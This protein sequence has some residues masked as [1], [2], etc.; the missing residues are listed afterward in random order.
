MMTKLAKWTLVL[1]IVVGFILQMSVIWP[2]GSH[3]CFNSQC[4]IFFWG[5]NEHDAVWHL[6]LENTA[7][8]TNPAQMPN[9][10]GTPLSGYNALMDQVLYVISYVTGISVA[11]LYFKIIP[12][13]WFVALTLLIIKLA[14]KIS[15]NPWYPPA[16]LFFVYLG[17]SFSYFLTLWHN[18]TW[19]GGSG[20]LS[21]QAPQTL[22]NI[23]FGL[24]LPILM[25]ILI[26]MHDE[27]HRLAKRLILAGLVAVMW[28]L[29]F[30]GGA[31][32]AAMVGVYYLANREQ[33]GWKQTLSGLFILG[34]MTVGAIGLFYGVN[35]LASGGST[36]SWSPLTTVHPIIEEDNL[37]YLPRLANARYSLIAQG[38][39]PKL[40]LIEA[41][42][43]IIFMVLNFGTRILGLWAIGAQ[44]ARH[45]LK[46]F[47]LV[48]GSGI[49]LSFLFS[50]LLVQKGVWWNTVQFLYYSLFLA[51]IYAAQTIAQLLGKKR[52]WAVASAIG[53]IALT[54]PNA[55]DTWKTFTSF[56]P[57]SYIS[58]QEMELLTILKKQPAGVVLALPLAATEIETTAP[59]APLYTRYDTSYVAAYGGHP[60][61]L[62]DLI[63]LQ[64][65][66]IDY[67]VR[68]KEIEGADCH[69]LGQVKYL[70]LA[71]DLAQLNNWTDCGTS[72]RVI[73]QNAAGAI[74]RVGD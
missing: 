70:Y 73:T 44:I 46:K 7:F 21:M 71:G 27:Q 32:A 19:S 41:L 14:R 56:P 45:Q 3:Y 54:L 28:G 58:D 18:G 30:Y 66:G 67:S 2:S 6:A 53:V 68:Q 35:S 37:A 64:L 34:L 33:N 31:V 59:L 26:L 15:D 60:T 65:T 63:Q 43:L 8:A 17:N 12:I 25:G 24:S 22:T 48:V 69:V 10:S 57:R 16:L 49:T 4:G 40:I 5:S 39:G 74:Y 42:T 62:N 52:W 20:L 50:I 9:Y 55:A 38:V 29:K 36:F 72:I 1:G 13:L 51:N 61:Y 47:D 11:F 23:Q